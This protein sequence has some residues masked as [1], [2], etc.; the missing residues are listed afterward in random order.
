MK[1]N[2]YAIIAKLENHLKKCNVIFKENFPVVPSELLLNVIPM[3][4]LPHPHHLKAKNPS[5]TLICNFSQDDILYLSLKEIDNRIA[6]WKNFMGICGFDFSARVGDDEVNQDLYMYLNKLL[7]AYVAIHGVK[8]LPNFR[9]TGNLASLNMLRIYPPNGIFAVGT[10]GC[11][12]NKEFN[13]TLLRYKILF[14]RTKHLLVYG[15]LKD[16][17]RKIL[18]EYGVKFTVFEDFHRRSRKGEFK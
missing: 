12:E 1:I 16:V 11:G 13:S 3:E 15:T 5:N 2:L 6:V 18:D 8:V 9:T 4:I 17:Y 7:D 14:T 10:L